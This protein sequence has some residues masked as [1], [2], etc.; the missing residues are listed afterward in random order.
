MMMNVTNSE[1]ALK[2]YCK[3]KGY[4]KPIY[5]IESRQSII[6][7]N[8]VYRHKHYLCSVKVNGKHLAN[9]DGF[10]KRIAR[11]KAAMFGLQNLRILELTNFFNVFRDILPQ[12][13]LEYHDH[14][15]GQPA[16][17]QLNVSFQIASNSNQNEN[18]YN[19]ILPQ[20]IRPTIM[21][22]PSSSSTNN[23]NDND[24]NNG[25]ENQQQQ[26]EPKSV[27][28]N[29]TKTSN[30]PHND[31]DDPSDDLIRAAIVKLRSYNDVVDEIKIYHENNNGNGNAN[32]QMNSMDNKRIMNDEQPNQQQQQQQ[33]LNHIQQVMMNKI[34]KLNIQ[35]DVNNDDKQS[36]IEPIEDIVDNDDKNGT[37]L[38]QNEKIYKI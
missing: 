5:R 36:I 9:G 16:N 10:S 11:K 20:N 7:E 1:N 26:Q 22:K 35:D 4:E 29:V 25:D 14:Q 27:K 23:D 32:N 31:D 12:R 15:R 38:I 33:Q 21:E 19:E 2:S 30:S 18:V 37:K 24:Q 17:I 3:S 6:L 34:H 28:I 8:N 13:A